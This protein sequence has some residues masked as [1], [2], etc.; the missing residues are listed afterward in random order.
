MRD[1]NGD[2]DIGSMMLGGGIDPGGDLSFGDDDE[3]MIG[4]DGEEESEFFFFF[5]WGIREKELKGEEGER[6]RSLYGEKC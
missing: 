4:V 2:F 5:S 6:G 3:D 1:K